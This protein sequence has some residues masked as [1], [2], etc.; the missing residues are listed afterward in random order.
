MLK[1]TYFLGG[2]EIKKIVA[3]VLMLL[4][5][6]S[7]VACTGGAPAGEPSTEQSPAGGESSAPAET[8]A[9]A[10][11][12]ALATTASYT[13]GPWSAAYTD[14]T[15]DQ[16][17]EKLDTQLYVLCSVRF[18]SN[19]YF[20]TIDEGCQM[21]CEYLDTIGQKYSYECVTNEKNSDTQIN[22]IS[23]FLAKANGNGII[24]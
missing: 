20:V 4:M 10:D 13:E 23:A 16:L 24:F 8:S 9:E 2:M 19:P 15:A 11:L 17:Q 6:F 14:I 22:Q 18:L 1:K 21:F 12:P 7:L 3:A 5:V